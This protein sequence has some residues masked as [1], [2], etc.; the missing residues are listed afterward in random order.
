MII[1]AA[2]WASYQSYKDRKPPWI[3]L[4]KSLLDNY[5][6]QSMGTNARALLPMLWLLASEHQDPTSGIINQDYKKIAF[7]LRL[8]IKDVEEGIEEIVSAC[9][10]EV[11]SIRNDSVTE[12]LQDGEESVT[13]E[14][15]TET[16]T[17]TYTRANPLRGFD[18]FWDALPKGKKKSKGTA[19]RAWKKLKIDEQLFQLIM[20]GLAKAKTSEAWLSDGGKFIPHPATWLNAKGWE[21]DVELFTPG[22]ENKVSPWEVLISKLGVVDRD[23]FPEFDD[24]LISEALFKCGSWMELSR[25]TDKQAQF[26]F[27]PK[28]EEAY[29]S[30]GGVI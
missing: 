8:S 27:K 21:D 25:M 17:E 22:Q 5:E 30:L 1:K 23:K 11:I 9:F 28:F 26:Q 12:P 4:H 6:Y 7:R 29:Q 2:N 20:K 16:E 15:E 18:T 10:F 3:R 19:E 13:P 24:P 14:T